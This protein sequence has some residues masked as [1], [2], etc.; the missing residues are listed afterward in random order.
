MDFPSCLCLSWEKGLSLCLS[1]EKGPFFMLAM[2]KGTFAMLVTGKRICFMLV[3]GISRLLSGIIKLWQYFFKSSLTPLKKAVIMCKT[4]CNCCVFV[5]D[6]NHSTLIAGTMDLIFQ[7]VQPCQLVS[8]IS[9]SWFG[10]A[11]WYIISVSWFGFASWYVSILPAGRMYQLAA[12]SL[13]VSWLVQ[14]CLKASWLEKK[15]HIG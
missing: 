10:F 8:F 15:M 4:L 12:G 6:I 7:L 5:Y 3:T 9:V 1:W 2:G 11:S 14:Y 13:F